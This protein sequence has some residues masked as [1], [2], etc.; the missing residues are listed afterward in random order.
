MAVIANP[1]VAS[2]MSRFFIGGKVSIKFALRRYRRLD[3]RR[4][5]FCRIKENLFW[6]GNIDSA[7]DLV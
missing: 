7:L 2:V 6:V 3:F 5:Q 1:A 4:V